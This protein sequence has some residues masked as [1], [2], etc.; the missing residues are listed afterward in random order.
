MYRSIEYIK[1]L[2]DTIRV[3]VLRYVAMRYDALRRDRLLLPG[4]IFS[5][6]SLKRATPLLKRVNNI[7]GK[8]AEMHIGIFLLCNGYQRNN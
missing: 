5:V 2:I 4:K 1:A 3:S 6:V 8:Q 7:A